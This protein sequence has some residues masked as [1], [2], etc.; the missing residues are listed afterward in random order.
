MHT[1]AANTAPDINRASA[2]IFPLLF[3]GKSRLRRFCGQ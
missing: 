3:I 2:M 1:A